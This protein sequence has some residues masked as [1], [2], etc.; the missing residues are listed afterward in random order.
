MTEEEEQKYFVDR[1]HR[2]REHIESTII[3]DIEKVPTAMDYKS[4]ESDIFESRSRY[5]MECR[6]DMESQDD[7]LT[8]R[9][10]EGGR[11]HSTHDND[12]D[13]VVAEW[14]SND[15]FD[16]ENGDWE[17]D[18]QDNNIEGQFVSPIGKIRS[19][20]DESD[21]DSS[22][23]NIGSFANNMN[24]SFDSLAAQTSLGASFD[25]DG[26]SKMYNDVSRNFEEESFIR[27]IAQ[28]Y[29]E[30]NRAE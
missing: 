23:K 9:Y 10:S 2:F 1:K 8:D 30:I 17:D 12:I 27:K 5:D 24:P 14:K 26:T 28:Q 13:S 21:N 7:E 18:V 20:T 22:N 4:D 16:V 6:S 25:H 11:Q 3:Q 29:G 19:I 15:E